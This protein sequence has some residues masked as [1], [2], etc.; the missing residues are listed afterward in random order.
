MSNPANL[1]NCRLVAA[2]STNSFGYAEPAYNVALSGHHAYVARAQRLSVLNVKTHSAPVEVGSHFIGSWVRS[3]FLTGNRAY[4]AAET[5]G[6]I[7][8]DVSNPTNCV[9]LGTYMPPGSPVD[10]VVSGRLAFVTYGSQGDLDDLELEIVDVS[11]PASCLSLG[12][13]DET[14]VYRVAV[15]GTRVFVS[16]NHGRNLTVLDVS[17]PANPAHVTTLNIGWPG[18][19]VISAGGRI[20][21]AGG[22]AGLFVIP[23]ILDV[24]FALRVD[25]ALGVPF[26][27]ESA[28]NLWVPDAWSPLL[29][30]NVP[31]MPFDYVDCDVKRSERPHKYYRVRQP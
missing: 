11:T 5:N 15:A 20:L 7:I 18:R 22:P 13:Y 12:E 28:T 30:T 29:T 9:R 2:D 3:V 26:T 8:F 19:D 4:V 16:Q 6:L 14:E 31:V 1:V 21:L 10:V 24:Q 27:L 23:T 25:A 17:N